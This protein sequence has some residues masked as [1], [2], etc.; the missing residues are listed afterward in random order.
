MTGE[1]RNN[2]GR[3][4][5]ALCLSDEAERHHTEVL[6]PQA[7]LGEAAAD[8]A[9]SVPFAPEKVRFLNDNAWFLAT[10]PDASH[11]DGVTAVKPGRM[12]KQRH[13]MQDA[14]AMGHTG[15][16]LSGDWTVRRCR[17]GSGKGDRAVIRCDS[18]RAW[19]R[20]S[21]ASATPLQENAYPIGLTL[22]RSPEVFDSS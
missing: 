15:G 4:V 12:G 9:E 17:N 21:I 16:G 8:F 1:A 19:P 11:R 3:V 5:Q 20:A 2:A 6:R 13:G 10:C 14:G 7:H 18:G 22:G